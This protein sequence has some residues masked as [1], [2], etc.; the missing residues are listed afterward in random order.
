M[1]I[2][3]VPLLRTLRDLYDLPRDMARFRRYLE[4]RAGGWTGA[5]RCNDASGRQRRKTYLCR[6]VEAFY[7][8]TVCRNMR[9]EAQFSR[10][11]CVFLHAFANY[12]RI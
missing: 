4:I 7:F 1:D 5:H 12:Y 3:Y 2:T 10:L 11:F 8:S 9:R 6:P